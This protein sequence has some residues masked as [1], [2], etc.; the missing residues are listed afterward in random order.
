MTESAFSISH[1]HVITPTFMHVLKYKYPEYSTPKSSFLLFFQS[2]LYIESMVS[3]TAQILAGAAVVGTGLILYQQKKQEKLQTPISSGRS[4][5]NPVTVGSGIAPAVDNHT[6]WSQSPESKFISTKSLGGPPAK[7]DAYNDARY[8][9]EQAQQKFEDTKASWWQ[10][11]QQKSDEVSR[12]SEKQYE[13]AKAK[14]EDATQSL[15]EQG[16]DALDT[17]DSQYQT[18]KSQ[19]QSKLND[20]KEKT[21]D[22]VSQA[23]EQTKSF[24]SEARSKLDKFRQEF[25]SKKEEL[26]KKYAHLSEEEL[27]GK[28]FESLRGWGES[29]EAFARE[30]YLES[31]RNAAETRSTLQRGYDLSQQ[32]LKEAQ[33]EFN[34]TKKAWFS[35]GKDQNEEA[36]NLASRKLAEAQKSFDDASKQL[37]QFTS[38]V[39][40]SAK[41]NSD[42]VVQKTK[43]GLDVANDKA[44]DGLS[45]VS[46]WIRK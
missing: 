45:S 34:R 23:K 16:Q 33:D 18:W 35:W 38:S 28:A 20:A 25:N 37:D 1:L 40:K 21:D 26:R 11:G 32:K 7:Q 13:I 42:F 2:L 24:S 12:E 44:Q 41:D 9:F 14:L 36:H 6:R 4:G 39:A 30:E 29:A 5:N 8:Q 43:E 10:W 17:A 15:R 46:N 19:W 22:L 3:K 31:K 27:D